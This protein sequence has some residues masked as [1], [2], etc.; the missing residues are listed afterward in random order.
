ML[1]QEGIYDT[2]LEIGGTLDNLLKY[3]NNKIKD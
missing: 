2:S 3:T 1:Y